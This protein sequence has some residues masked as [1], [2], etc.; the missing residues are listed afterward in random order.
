MKNKIIY[1]TGR[2][3]SGSTIL[4]LVLGN[5]FNSISFGEFVSGVSR[6]KEQFCSCG[7]NI[8]ECPFWSTVINEIEKRGLSFDRFSF[9]V[10]KYS[11]ILQF[12][13]LYFNKQ[14]YEEFKIYHSVFFEIINNLFDKDLFI[15]SSKEPSRSL[16][17]YSVFSNSFVIHLVRNPFDVVASTFK[18]VKKGESVNFLR[19]KLTPTKFNKVLI[20]SLFSFNWFIGNLMIEI[21]KLFMAK[22]RYIIFSYDRFIKNPAKE[23]KN[24]DNNFK[25]GLD[26]VIFKVSNGENLDINHTLGGNRIR[27]KKSFVLSPSIFS[28][29]LSPFYICLVFLFT[30]PLYFFYKL[31]K[32]F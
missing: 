11:N 28:E 24:L 16:F 14:L 29:K 18:R 20:V 13:K 31:K 23:L 26:D 10:Y 4:D 8:L 32:L 19:K 1:I 9:I 22:D 21:F 3:H 17:Y 12:Y 25:L 30:F 2:G 6:Y 5:K 7:M 15:D 27:F